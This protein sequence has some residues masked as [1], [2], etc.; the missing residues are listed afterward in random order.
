MRQNVNPLE[1]HFINGDVAIVSALTKQWDWLGNRRQ[2]PFI[3]DN[4]CFESARCQR[5]GIQ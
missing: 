5:G 4:L 2:L 3:G 1:D